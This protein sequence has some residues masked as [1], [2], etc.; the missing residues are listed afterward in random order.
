MCCSDGVSYQVPLLHG[1]SITAIIKAAGATP[2]TTGSVTIAGGGKQVVLTRPD[3]DPS[4]P[5]GIDFLEGPAQIYQSAATTTTLNF[6]RPMRLPAPADPNVLDE[7]VTSP[8]EK[9]HIDIQ[10]GVPLAVSA[11]ASPTRVVRRRERALHRR[12]HRQRLP[13]RS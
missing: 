13:A 10:T 3:F 9:L 11:H 4:R 8:G 6:F 7:I 5:G 12:R 1:W 2:E